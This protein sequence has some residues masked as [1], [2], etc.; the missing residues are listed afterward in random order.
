MPYILWIVLVGVC[1][2]PI[3]T[4]DFLYRSIL[5]YVFWG[6]A[7]LYL[8][9]VLYKTNKAYVDYTMDFLIVT[10]KE[11]IKYN[12]EWLLHRET[13]NIPASKIKSISIKKDGLMNS[14]FDIGSIVFLAEWNDE[15][16]DIVMQDIDAIEYIEKKIKHV[17]GL[18]RR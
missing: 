12:Q 5:I 7:L 17:M 16:G 11:L 18:D 10:P 9:V 14:F 8:L 1:L 3:Y 2:Y 13:E 15:K 6:F 4:T